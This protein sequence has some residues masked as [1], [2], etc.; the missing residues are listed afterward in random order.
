VSLPRKQLFGDVKIGHFFLTGKGELA[1][2]IFHHDISENTLIFQEEGDL[3]HVTLEA[4]D[5]VDPCGVDM[6]VLPASS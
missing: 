6:A 1:L 2:K 3:K 5:F 4:C